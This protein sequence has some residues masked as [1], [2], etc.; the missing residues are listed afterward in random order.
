VKPIEQSRRAERAADT[1]YPYG[2]PPVPRR[3]ERPRRSMARII[4]G[5]IA[6]GIGVTL[7]GLTLTGLFYLVLLLLYMLFS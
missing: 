3:E 5:K 6:Y 4:I 7:A 1:G 2:S